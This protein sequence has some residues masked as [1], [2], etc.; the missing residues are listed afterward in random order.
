VPASER[1]QEGHRRFH[2]Q[3]DSHDPDERHLD[4]DD[5]PIWNPDVLERV[6]GLPDDED[7]EVERRLERDHFD[8]GLD[9]NHG[10]YWSDPD[11]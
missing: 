9:D 8:V 6:E 11:R 1:A 5:V 4:P 3:V 2:E 7:R 10:F